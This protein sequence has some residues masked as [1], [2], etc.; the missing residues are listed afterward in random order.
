MSNFSTQLGNWNPQLLREYRGRLRSRSII[1]AI[2]LSAIAQILL[3]VVNLPDRAFTELTSQEKW[4]NLWTN[5]TWIIPYALFA[6]GSYY[7]VSDLTQE[8]QRGT[9]NF[10][11]L[12]PYPSWKVLLGK[13]LGVPVLPYL[14][15]ALAIPLHLVATIQAELPLSLFFSYYL[16]LLAGCIFWY[17]VAMLYGLAGGVQVGVVNR[18]AT[19]A[20]AFTALTLLVFTQLFM[21]WNISFI[22][23]WIS[24]QAFA[25][26]GL[27]VVTWFYIPLTNNVGFAHLFTLTILGI[28]T[29]R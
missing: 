24:N 17:S 1:A 16:L 12:T 11:R 26:S 19:T 21:L 14:T 22:W 18:Q 4:L 9:L 28:S 25:F 7:L 23:G 20:I 5:M 2:A 3:M 29:L 6:I 15:I 8:E 27:D 13:L 10:I